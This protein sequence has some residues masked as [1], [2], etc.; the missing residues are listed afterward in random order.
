MEFLF[1]LQSQPYSLFIISNVRLFRSGQIFSNYFDPVKTFFFLYSNLYFFFRNTYSKQS[2][3]L[4]EVDQY[5]T[6]STTLSL[7]VFLPFTFFYFKTFVLVLLVF[8]CLFWFSVCRENRER[9]QE[10]KRTWS[11]RRGRW[12]RFGRRW[13]FGRGENMTIVWQKNK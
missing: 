6:I 2:I 12:R 9:W 8:V 10:R 13:R 3:S 5:K 4:G 1:S 11:L 7:C